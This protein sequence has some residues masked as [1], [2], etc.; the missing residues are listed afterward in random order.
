[1]MHLM[2]LEL[3]KVGLKKYIM[4]AIAG[5]LISMYFLLVGLNDS[6]TV[7]DSYETAFTMVGMIFCF[8]YVTLFSVLVSSYIVNE[9]NHKTILILFSYPIGHKKLMAAKLL[10]ITLLVTVSMTIGYICCGLLIIMADQYFGIIKGEFEISVLFYWIPTALK[11]IITFCALG[12]GTFVAGMI[13]KSVPMTIVSAMLFCYIRQF[14]IAGR[15]LH[16][17]DWPFVIGVVAVTM[18]GVYYTLTCKIG[19]IE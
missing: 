7:R 5:I 8:Y 19:K 9:Y 11:A 15:N 3:R 14:Y 10:L 2:K 6:S 18:A 1:M 17:E 12:V 13:K 4:I 16:G